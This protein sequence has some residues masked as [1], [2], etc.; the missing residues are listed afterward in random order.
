MILICKQL[1]LANTNDSQYYKERSINAILGYI[2][3]SG[4]K[5]YE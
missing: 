3:Y 5:S 1:L 2:P 4:K